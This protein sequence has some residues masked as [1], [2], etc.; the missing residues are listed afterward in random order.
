ML[1]TILDVILNKNPETQIDRCQYSIE[2]VERLHEIYSR[3]MEIYK[4]IQS[5]RVNSR[6][7]VEFEVGDMVYLH[8]PNDKA[9]L[10]RKFMTRFQGP[11]YIIEKVSPVNYVLN[12]DNKNTT[13]HIERLR[14]VVQDD[15][16]KRWSEEIE[17]ATHELGVYNNLR[18]KLDDLED[19]AQF[20]LAVNRAE[21]NIE[22]N[23]LSQENVD[24]V[25]N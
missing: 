22:Q 2:L 12:I 1:R 20:N 7:T 23:Y 13:V 5:K 17:L 8:V 21:V 25:Q 24:Q 9:G 18:K 16:M 11:Y 10:A 6:P 4:D 19:R 15:K 14:R 3:V